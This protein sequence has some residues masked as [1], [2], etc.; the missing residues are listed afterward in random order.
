[1]KHE[2]LM[3]E[4]K[5]KLNELLEW[6]DKEKDIIF[7]D[8]PVYL[9]VGDLLIH[10]GTECFFEENGIDIKLRLSDLNFDV[11]YINEKYPNGIVIC[12]GGGNFGDTYLTHQNVRD[13]LIRHYK[14]EIIVLPQS[15]NFNEPENLKKCIELYRENQNLHL[16]ARDE[17]SYSIMK[18]MTDKVK[19]LPDMAHYMWTNR[20]I[21]KGEGQLNFIRKDNEA[22]GRNKEYLDENSK[23]WEDD[24]SIFDRIVLKSFLK[25]IPYCKRKLLANIAAK[26]WIVY[27]NY[28]IKRVEELFSTYNYVVTSRLHGHILS[29][30]LYIPNEVI[31]NSYKKNTR[32]LECWTLKSDSVKCLDFYE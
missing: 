6:I 18:Q 19:L 31:D 25:L 32:Y 17:Y 5:F 9:N 15:V 21:N 23:D 1:M 24:F 27:S 20:S 2:Q 29:C 11:N 7:V 14:G 13:E 8:M 28:K 12:Q 16:C 26:S 10:K 4:L 22:S 30:L 3:T